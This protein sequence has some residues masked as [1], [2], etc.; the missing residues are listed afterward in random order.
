VARS[1]NKKR[2]ES[3]QSLVEFALLL[4]IML[5]VLLGAVNLGLAIRAQLQLAQVTQQGAQY[6]VHHAAYSEADA[7]T[8]TNSTC[9][10]LATYSKLETYMSGLS[11]YQLTPLEVCVAPGTSSIAVNGTTSLVQQDTVTVHY[12]FHLIFPMIGALSVGML[13]NGNIN[14]G[15][16]ASTIA[17]THQVG[18]MTMCTV[19]T[20]NKRQ[21]GNNCPDVNFK[22]TGS[23]ANNGYHEILWKPPVE[24]TSLGLPLWYCVQRTWYDTNHVAT[25]T[26]YLTAKNFASVNALGCVSARPS[27]NILYPGYFYFVDNDTSFESS[28]GTGGLQYSVSAI[29]ANGLL[30]KPAY[31]WTVF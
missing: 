18:A 11:S 30:S 22:V 8:S 20:G 31:V 9:P 26:T 15:A 1:L 19:G 21:P 27:T 28:L 14:L 23:G 16:T 2:A 13:S 17:A 10:G 24:A 5:L 7:A 3:G 6:L 29:Q 4:P 12:P 25:T